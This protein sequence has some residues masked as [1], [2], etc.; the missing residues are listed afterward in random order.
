MNHQGK[1]IFDLWI[2]IYARYMHYLLLHCPDRMMKIKLLDTDEG[3]P[4]RDGMR[5]KRPTNGDEWVG[6]DVCITET[7]GQDVALLAPDSQDE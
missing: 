4:M 1:D 7:W 6:D 2:Y 3:H 5:A